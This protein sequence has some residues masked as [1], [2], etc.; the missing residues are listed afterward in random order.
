VIDG[1]SHE[2]IS[3]MLSISVGTSKSNLFKA[4]EHLKKMLHDIESE[5]G[6]EFKYNSI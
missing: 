2:E 4:R 6:N 5:A 3:D 1:Y